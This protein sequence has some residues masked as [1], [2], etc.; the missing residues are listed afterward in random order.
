VADDDDDD[1]VVL[2]TCFIV[3]L[4]V[5]LFMDDGCGFNFLIDIIC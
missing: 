3:L 4:G 2:S 5:L 1:F